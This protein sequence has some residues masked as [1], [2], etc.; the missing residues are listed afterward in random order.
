M[1]EAYGRMGISM[2][3]YGRVLK[4]ARTIA[5]IDGENDIGESHIAEALMYRISDK[6]EAR[7]AM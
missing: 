1:T 2:R 6:N 4:V 7:G 5:D 3:A